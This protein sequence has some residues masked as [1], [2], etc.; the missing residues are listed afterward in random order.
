MTSNEVDIYPVPTYDMIYI[1]VANSLNINIYNVSGQL[2]Y[3][4][5]NKNEDVLTVDVSDW[6]KSVYF[7]EIID[8]YLNKKTRKFVVK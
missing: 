7:V 2:V 8:E 1:N 3:S 6:K 5:E 4:A